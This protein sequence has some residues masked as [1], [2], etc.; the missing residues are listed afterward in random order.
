MK[1]T[2]VIDS[3][4]SLVSVVIEENGTEIRKSIL[5]RE[6]QKACVSV[7]AGSGVQR[8]GKLP[9]GFIDGG[10]DGTNFEAIIKVPGGKRPF[11][12]LET[13]YFIPFPDMVFHFVAQ[14]G[15]VT[16]TETWFADEN[17]VLYHYP[18][19]NVYV[20][21][22]ICWGG[23]LL[24]SIGCL[25][26][27]EKLVTLFYSASTN[28]D[29]YQNVETKIGGRKVELTQRELLELVSKEETFP[30]KLLKPFGLSIAQ[31]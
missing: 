20:N 31:L 27:F 7:D 23:N 15:R 17:G 18:Y 22:A 3:N 24:P 30:K 4:K 1:I 21:G 5:F 2:S 29:L 16:A 28:N 6:Y 9:E 25:K 14:K 11:K 8:V 19:G 13:E 10:V 12:Y 26:D